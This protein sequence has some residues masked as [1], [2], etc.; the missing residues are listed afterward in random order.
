MKSLKILCLTAASLLSYQAC[1]EDF[2]LPVLD[3]SAKSYV[4][5]IDIE[6]LE[7]VNKNRG[8][9]V[10]IPAGNYSGDIHCV[11]N[12]NPMTAKIT[13]KLKGD[14]KRAVS[15]IADGNCGYMYLN[16]N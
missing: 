5:S 11:V 6:G 1:A 9:W 10:S 15:F 7:S 13:L 2:L 14:S 4:K 16:K 8:N 3:T 12:R